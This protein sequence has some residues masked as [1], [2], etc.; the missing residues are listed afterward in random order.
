MVRLAEKP[1]SIEHIYEIK[2]WMETIP[3]TVRTQEDL[4]KRYL[5]VRDYLFITATLVDFFRNTK[6]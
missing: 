6:F 4:T 3:L 5:L 1:Q 2:E